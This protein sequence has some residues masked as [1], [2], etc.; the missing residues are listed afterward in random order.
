MRGLCVDARW[1]CQFVAS[2]SRFPAEGLA[3][4]GDF[5]LF[6]YLML[7][8]PSLS[9]FNEFISYTMSRLDHDNNAAKTP[10][11]Y[12]TLRGLEFF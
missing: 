5:K 9:D 4:H 8:R 7:S 6:R 12:T 3:A 10:D 1:I 2:P 11:G